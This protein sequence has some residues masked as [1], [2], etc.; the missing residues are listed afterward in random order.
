VNRGARRSPQDAAEI[1]ADHHGAPGDLESGRGGGVM[2]PFGF[3]NLG[4]AR[5]AACAQIRGDLVCLSEPAS[6]ALATA[7]YS[8]TTPVLVHRQAAPTSDAALNTS[9]SK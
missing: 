1:M 3:W 4:R 6:P 5:L 8:Y 2:R 7:Q 9:S